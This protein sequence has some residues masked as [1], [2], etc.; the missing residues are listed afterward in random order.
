MDALGQQLLNPPAHIPMSIE[1]LISH[2]HVRLFIRRYRKPNLGLQRESRS[3][4]ET[5]S[6][7]WLQQCQDPV[8][9]YVEVFDMR[10]G[11]CAKTRAS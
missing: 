9:T 5:N 2:R 10:T 7:H 3:H 6:N 8:G 1:E 11:T 4:I